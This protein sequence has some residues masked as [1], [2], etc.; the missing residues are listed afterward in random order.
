MI[1]RVSLLAMSVVLALGVLTSTLQGQELPR[2]V[3]LVVWR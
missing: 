2:V 1:R 3:V